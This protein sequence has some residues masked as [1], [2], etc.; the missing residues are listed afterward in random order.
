MDM[1]LTLVWA[2]SVLGQFSFRHRLLAW[3]TYECHLHPNVQSSLK[4]KK[5]DIV[6]T[7]GGAVRNIFNFPMFAGINHLRIFALNTMTVGSKQRVFTMK[8]QLE[9][10]DHH[11]SDRFC[12]GSWMAWQEL[13]P[14]VIRDSFKSC[15]L[16]TV[17]DGSEDADIHCF[18]E[19]QPCSSGH[20]ML[21]E[22][23]KI[24]HE[25]EDDPFIPDDDDVS[26]A[27]PLDLLIDDNESDDHIDIME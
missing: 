19:G 27:A 7:P 4:A 6:I 24:M 21:A 10:Y 2:N 23:M 11:L 16:L 9:S 26:E 17:L 22:Q 25:T 18:K 1:N 13:S 3:D 14:E 5:I 12:N 8:R 20:E 15:G